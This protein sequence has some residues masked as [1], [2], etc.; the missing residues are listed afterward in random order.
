MG[1]L[2]TGPGSIAIP[3]IENLIKKPVNYS[4]T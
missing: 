3:C 4:T 2:R 1:S